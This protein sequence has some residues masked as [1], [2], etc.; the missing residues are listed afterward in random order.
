[1]S[2]IAR[3]FSA[4]A[5]YWFQGSALESV[6]FITGGVQR[7]VLIAMRILVGVVL[8]LVHFG[9]GTTLAQN[10]AATQNP[11]DLVPIQ[12]AVKKADSHPKS[13]VPGGRHPRRLGDGV[14]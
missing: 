3:N 13:V 9:A 10:Q 4:N 12:E 5:T 1:M 2:Q 11:M 6:D 7:E 8:L 14:I